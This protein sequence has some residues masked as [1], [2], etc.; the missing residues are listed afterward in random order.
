MK[1]L[2]FVNRLVYFSAAFCMIS[3]LLL[4]QNCG[5]NFQS[6]YNSL[7]EPV[8]DFQTSVTKIVAPE[9]ITGI[10]GETAILSVYVPKA[11]G[12]H[13]VF[14]WRRNGADLQGEIYSDLILSN[15]KTE[16]A[17][18]YYLSAQLFD[19]SK[20]ALVGQPETRGISLNVKNPPGAS[21]P[22]I[23]MDTKG[24]SAME[25]DFTYLRV[26]V[27]GYPKPTVQWF[28][29]DILLV[30][31]N[32]DYLI[33]NS[34]QRSQTG[35]YKA[36]VSNNLGTIESNLMLVLVNQTSAAPKLTQIS[37]SQNLA[38]N[39]TLNLSAGVTGFPAPTFQWLRDDV[40]I[41]GAT[42]SSLKVT[43]VTS[44]NSGLYKLVSKNSAGVL[45]STVKVIV[46]D[47]ITFSQALASKTVG[48]NSNLELKVMTTSQVDK[49][50][51][52]LNGELIPG[53]ATNTLGLTS[54]TLPPVG[55]SYW[56][57]KVRA[58][59]AVGSVES[60]MNLTVTPGP[61]LKP[62]AAVYIPFDGVAQ[63]SVQIVSGSGL[64][65]QWF[66]DDVAIPGNNSQYL[67]VS[68]LNPN[69]NGIYKVQ[70]TNVAGM[71]ETSAPVTLCLAVMEIHSV[72]DF[73]NYFLPKS[74]VCQGSNFA[75]KADLDFNNVLRNGV[76]FSNASLDGENHTI[77]NV[78]IID[79]STAD[80]NTRLGGVGLFSRLYAATVMNLKLDHF[81]I[82]GGYENS[83]GALAGNVGNATFLN[84]SLSNS[85]VNQLSGTSYPN[86]GSIIGT[87]CN[88]TI[89]YS[90]VESTQINSNAASGY[91]G[92]LVGFCGNGGV[93][94]IISDSFS[95][96]YRVSLAKP[97]EALPLMYLRTDMFTARSFGA[98][99]IESN[100]VVTT[101]FDFK[102]VWIT[103]SPYP[104]L[105]HNLLLDSSIL[106]ASTV[107]VTD[108]R[109]NKNECFPITVKL[110]NFKG[111]AETKDVDV[112]VKLISPL[113]LVFSNL[114]DCN[115]NIAV[116][117]VT[118]LAGTSSASVYLKNKP[119]SSIYAGQQF[120]L[121]SSAEG[122]LASAS[123]VQSSYTYGQ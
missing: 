61:V 23:N 118:V 62:L 94:T 16:D 115:A 96:A 48:E 119:T 86:V 92:G 36:T 11:T 64:T 93:S 31:E 91:F 17:G 3:L 90:S 74:S 4:F 84:I 109:L 66:K 102:N 57:Y 95:T 26:V 100:T 65:F 121:Y 105:R 1:R 82:I 63:L 10:M 108:A 32:R 99:N 43:N 52:F 49:Y 101:G 13:F 22:V 87:F 70:A 97:Y 120:M 34:I 79:N 68:S 28:F 60:S 117:D 37:E 50:E 44:A 33:F 104:N 81:D 20:N 6:S 110:S 2:L 39:S 21:A 69:V 78:K 56:T 67:S 7:G 85:S 76:L 41:S 83:V 58:T 103:A 113:V 47:S 75:L 51:W 27:D 89:A 53:A 122:Y 80:P 45:E 71:T 59:N 8:A 24:L 123:M 114:S 19:E 72:A 18:A 29:N 30:G 46:I 14:Q 15:L 106:K 54:I 111:A 25:G 98:D 55:Q 12:Y 38:K 88:A 116:S 73:D 40:L 112:K 42:Q 77:R 5:S 107:I 9:S 35:V